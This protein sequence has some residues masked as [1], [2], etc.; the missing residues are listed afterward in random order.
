MWDFLHRKSSS[1]EEKICTKENSHPTARPLFKEKEEERD[2]KSGYIIPKEPPADSPTAGAHAHPCRKCPYMKGGGLKHAHLLGNP[3]EQGVS[4]HPLVPKP[5]GEARIFTVALP[6]WLQSQ[7]IDTAE[8]SA[9]AAPTVT[10]A[11][12]QGGVSTRFHTPKEEGNHVSA[13]QHAC[14][15]AREWAMAFF[16]RINSLRSR[17]PGQ[18]SCFRGSATVQDQRGGSGSKSGVGRPLG[19]PARHSQGRMQSAASLSWGYPSFLSSRETEGKNTFER[20]EA[21]FYRNLNFESNECS[22][23]IGC[24]KIEDTGWAFGWQMQGVC[25]PLPPREWGLGGSWAQI[26]EQSSTVCT[27]LP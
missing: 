12:G 22:P 13:N 27:P 2:K 26:R 9:Y 17:H 24:H 6:T 10:L 7:C 15:R 16:W 20:M 19:G 23:K 3:P 18:A 8:G 21:T 25:H 14:S 4:V 5:L 11:G 1:G